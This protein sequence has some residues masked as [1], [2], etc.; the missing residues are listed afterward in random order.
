M[1]CVLIIAFLYN[2]DSWEFVKKTLTNNVKIV[3]ITIELQLN[4]T[5]KSINEFIDEFLI[6]RSFVKWLSVCFNSISTFAFNAFNNRVF[7]IVE[8]IISLFTE[9]NVIESIKVNKNAK[10]V[11]ML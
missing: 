11:E 4:K 7:C 10:K 3:L 1:C 9:I 8:S 6:K 5:I 2:F